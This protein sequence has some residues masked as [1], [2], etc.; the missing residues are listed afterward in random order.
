MSSS[1][2]RVNEA[3][4]EFAAAVRIGRVRSYGTSDVFRAG[5]H[6][7]GE[8]DAKA[9][10]NLEERRACAWNDALDAAARAIL[11]LSAREAGEARSAP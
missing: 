1:P 11:A 6:A 10:Q 8:A 4:E 2:E 5:W 7:R 9:V 3:F